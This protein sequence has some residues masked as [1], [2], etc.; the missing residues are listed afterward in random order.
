MRA[1][2]LTEFGPAHTLRCSEIPDPTAGP[3]EIVVAVAAASVNRA[4]L[5]YRSGRYHAGPPLPAVLGGEGAGTVAGIGP[6]VTGFEVGDR[7][8]TWGASGAPGCYAEQAAVGADRALAI[9]PEVELVAAAAV[10]IAWL[11]AWY[12]LRHLIKLGDGETVLITA[13]ASGVGSAAV[14]IAQDVG[15]TVIAVV[16]HDE[17]A[18]WVRDLGAHHVLNRTRDDVVERVRDLTSGRGAEAALD[19]TGGETFTACVRAVGHAGRVA[20]MA[21]VALAPST[22][23]T[24]DFYP[25]NASI[26]GFQINDLMGH[27]W[28]PR[29]DLTAIL[30]GIA[31]GR[32]RVPIEKTLPLEQAGLAHELL[33]SGEVRGKIVLT[34]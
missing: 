19:L 17:K 11:S 7:V 22:L 3:G 30:N 12:C 4:D 2:Q 10:P 1:V 27:G 21:N 8:V 9:P 33:E 6:G 28:D 32:F 23:D 25:K 31:A 16:G 13:A 14:Q 29:P 26:H 34:T 18:S 24:R 15:A 20:A 5:L